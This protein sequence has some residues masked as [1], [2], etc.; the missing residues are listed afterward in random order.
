MSL[1]S[2]LVCVVVLLCIA[3]VNNVLMYYKCYVNN[4]IDDPFVPE[5]IGVYRLNIY[6]NKYAYPGSLTG[7]GIRDELKSYIDPFKEKFYGR[8]VVSYDKPT[9]QEYQQISHLAN[10]NV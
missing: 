6:Y 9:T 3:I 8:Y 4:P 5:N 10:Y 7:D 2:C 1:R